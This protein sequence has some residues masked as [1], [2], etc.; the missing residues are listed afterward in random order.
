MNGHQNLFCPLYTSCPHTD[1]YLCFVYF[2]EGGRSG[3]ASI[4]NSPRRADPGASPA[5]AAAEAGARPVERAI[6]A[7]STDDAMASMVRHIY[8]TD[9]FLLNGQF[10]G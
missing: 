8:F 10:G 5:A 2:R 7:R 4:E 9:T 3:G 1:Y 6:E